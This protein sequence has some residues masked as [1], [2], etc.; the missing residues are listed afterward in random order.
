MDGLDFFG[1]GEDVDGA[2]FVV[3][4]VLVDADDD[5][6]SRFAFF[7][8]AVA[9][10]GDLSAEVSFVDASDGAAFV[11]GGGGGVLWFPGAASH[12][13]DLLDVV[14][15]FGFHFVGEFFDEVGTAEWVYGAGDSGFVC[16]DLLCAECDGDGLFGWEAEGFVHGVGVEGLASAE[17]ACHCLVGDAD[18]VVEWLLF[19][20]RAACGLDMGFHEP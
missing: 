14:E 4:G 7:G 12:V 16:E 5:A 20:E 6:I 1:D 15:C 17:D 13:V 2:F 10:F 19:C 11:D 8:E 9:G 18:D 3:V